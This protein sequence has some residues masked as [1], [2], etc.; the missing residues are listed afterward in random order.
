[1]LIITVTA[2]AVISNSV[3]DSCLVIVLVFN[4]QISLSLEF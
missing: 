3:E 1:M 4:L 2:Y